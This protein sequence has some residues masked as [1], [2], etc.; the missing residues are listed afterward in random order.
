MPLSINS[1]RKLFRVLFL[2]ALTIPSSAAFAQDP[3]KRLL[4]RQTPATTASAKTEIK[5]DGK[6]DPQTLVAALVNGKQ[7]TI[8][9]LAQQCRLRFGTEILDDIINK[10]MLMQACQAQNIVIEARDVDMEISRIASKFRLTTT[11]YLKLLEDERDIPREQ[12]ATEII[13]PMLAM[14]ALAK[15]TIVVT[16]QDIDREFQSQYGPKV[17]V[18]MIACENRE[19]IAKLHE[20]AVANPDSF[21]KLA[22][23]HSEDPDSASVE[24]LLPPIRRYLGDDELENIA[25]SLKPNEVSRVFQ[26]GEMYVIL[27]CVHHIEG[28][29]PP[30]PQMQEIEARIKSEI[31]EQKLRDSAETV[32]TSIREKGSVTLVHGD[33][34]LEAQYPGVAAIVNGQ[35]VLM[36]FYDKACVKR[37]GK[38]ILQ[39][40]INR[41]LVEEA[42]EQNRLAVTQQDLDAELANVADYFGFRDANGT[43]NVVGWL[44]DV[45]QREGL[46]RE[47]YLR[48]V[49]W[50]T[51]ALKKLT[52]GQVQVTE[53]DLQMGFESNYG[54][55]ADVL[56][57]VLSSQR[58]AQE[59]WNLA[60]GN[61]S[62][63]FFGE[64][65]AQYSV[66]PS[67]QSNYGV[68][69]PL[70]KH[71]GQPIMEKAAFELAPGELSGIIEVNGRYVLLKSRGLTT[72]VVS[73]MDDTVRKELYQNLIE[74]KQRQA[75]DQYLR[76]LF[77]EAEIVDFINAKNTRVRASEA[78]AVLDSKESSQR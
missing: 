69:P 59:V 12:Y 58:T 1:R 73:R 49:T 14:R 11:Q 61:T 29:Q 25:F 35:A 70:R 39:G 10:T 4:G 55:R 57:I 34:Q 27:Q 53:Q 6:A 63:Q 2:S 9:E 16:P 30:G 5:T 74:K 42:L 33:P 17:K 31:E 24:G 75:M 44:E 62:E 13:W 65:A 18:R 19:K 21:R 28:V 60:R 3:L 43:P 7:I 78:K 23:D 67:S 22:K 64:L 50:P 15:D 26:A 40:E 41:K 36:E 76:K 51:V 66:E 37:H 38:K 77:D 71:G 52:A 72:P 46:S 47:L 8:A 56:A 48:D 45:N 32:F 68:V 20:Q 54:P